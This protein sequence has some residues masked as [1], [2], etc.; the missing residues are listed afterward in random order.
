[1]KSLL[2]FA[3]LM[4]TAVAHAGDRQF[5]VEFSKETTVE[6]AVWQA[7]N[8]VDTLQ[9]IQIA[10]NPKCFQEVGQLGWFTGPHPSKTQVIEVS[11]LFS[12]AHYGTTLL[13]ENYGPRWAQRV[14]Q[15]GNFGYKGHTIIQNANYGIDLDHSRDCVR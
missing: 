6:E 11:A 14:W 5:S 3:S 15:F 1:M 10:K 8:V 13:L 2:L 7:M 4:L 12:V 9:T